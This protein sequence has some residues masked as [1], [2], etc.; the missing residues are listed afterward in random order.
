M[1][2]LLLFLLTCF[3]AWVAAVIRI[4]LRLRRMSQEGLEAVRKARESL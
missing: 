4:A 3:L 1:K 2:Y